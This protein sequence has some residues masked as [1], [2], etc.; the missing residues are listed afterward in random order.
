ML[1]SLPWLAGVAGRRDVT[2][3]SDPIFYDRKLTCRY[4]STYRQ[5]WKIS[6]AILRFDIDIERR[7]VSRLMLVIF[8]VILRVERSVE[9][10]GRDFLLFAI[11]HHDRTRT[12]S[13]TMIKLASKLTRF[14]FQ[15]VTMLF[16]FGRFEK[17][18][19][20]TDIRMSNRSMNGGSSR[21]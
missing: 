6:R 16:S 11:G 18:F 15:A 12:K 3:Y 5:H 21:G 9:R 20:D 2:E 17:K 4:D 1:I 7:F 14:C 13:T 10:I 19:T 8:L